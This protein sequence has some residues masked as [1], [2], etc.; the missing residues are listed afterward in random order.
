M[1]FIEKFL[2]GNKLHNLIK[3]I[4]LALAITLHLG[5]QLIS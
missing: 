5:P 3:K 4:I 2:K 1:G